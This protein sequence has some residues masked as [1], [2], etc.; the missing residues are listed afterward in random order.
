MRLSGTLK[1]VDDDAEG[2]FSS[3]GKIVFEKEYNH[4]L[5]DPSPDWAL[6]TVQLRRIAELLDELNR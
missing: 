1:L 6:N 3:I 2:K 4:H 5:F